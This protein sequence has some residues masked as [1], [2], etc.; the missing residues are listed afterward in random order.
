MHISSSKKPGRPFGVTIAIVASVI[1]YSLLPLAQIGL[2]LST[3]Q[4]INEQ[5]DAF[6]IPFEG[7]EVDSGETGGNVGG[8]SI[9]PLLLLQLGLSLFFIGIAYFAWRGSPSSRMIF[10]GTVLLM[11]LFTMGLIIGPQ[12]QENT[13]SSGGSLDGFLAS[14]QLG[15]LTL[16]VLV[17]I[18][19][20]WYLNRAPA[21]AFYRGYYLEKSQETGSA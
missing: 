1:V 17:P 11:T 7:E 21:R 10:M 5:N 19:V 18:Y 3:E 8:S 13:Q 12:L 16:I 15:Q 20:V 9:H 6:T 4:F 2:I 14:L